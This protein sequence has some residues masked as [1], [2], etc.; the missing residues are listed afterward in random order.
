MTSTHT[1]NVAGLSDTEQ[2]ARIVK[3]LA[4]SVASVSAMDNPWTYR[5]AMRL[6]DRV[7]ETGYVGSL[8]L[9]EQF[10][11]ADAAAALYGVVWYLDKDLTFTCTF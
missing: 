7:R 4:E 11:S 10:A 1:V 3:I 2:E 6:S 5:N 8:T 9:S